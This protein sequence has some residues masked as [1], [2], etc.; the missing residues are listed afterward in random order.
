[1]SLG[2]PGSALAG[3]RVIEIVDGL[4]AWC[5]KLLADMGAEVI[6]VEAPDGSA[7]R[8]L[9]P[10]WGER[11]DP[12]RSLSFLYANTSK[13][14][15]TLDLAC[16]EGAQNLRQLARGAD[17]IIESLPVGKL[18]QW[19]LS[20]EQLRIDNPALVMTSISDFG[21]SGPHSHYHGADIVAAA[22]GG[23]MCVVTDFGFGTV[24]SSLIAL[25]AK[26]RHGVAP[27]WL[28]SLGRPG[29][30]AYMPVSL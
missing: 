5:G 8:Q 7:E 2:E 21:Q 30:N 22:M 15:I 20:F 14:G 25:P 1:M 18:A 3:I 10:F 6:K 9:A 11:A 28:F 29:E 16:A 23:A 4:G 12:D 17:L 24:S 19:G 26:E 13:S 27:I